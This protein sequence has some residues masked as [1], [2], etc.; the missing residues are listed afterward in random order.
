M[1]SYSLNKTIKKIALVALAGV[2][3]GTGVGIILYANI[4]GD[5]VT[6]FQDGLHSIIN[7]SYGQASRIYNL[8]L[9]IIALICA[10]KYFGS[11]TIIS[12]LIVGF[13][14]DF[15]YNLLVTININNNFLTSLVF[16]TIGQ[17]IYSLGLALLIGCKLG[18]NALD[19]IIYKIKELMLID[20]KIIRFITDILLTTLG[21]LMGGVVGIGTVISIVCTG[22]MID[23]FTKIIKRGE[24]E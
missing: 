21:Y 9:I 13:L 10:R 17:S 7:I 4:G 20:Y 19:S 16:F 5:T 15:S 12:A 3:I 24:K 22:L 11:G 2:L 1:N 18:M 8:V 14:I 23:T 6:V